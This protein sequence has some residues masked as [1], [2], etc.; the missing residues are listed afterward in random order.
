MTSYDLLVYSSESAI[1]MMFNDIHGLSVYPGDF[2]V[3]HRTPS[4]VDDTIGF[5]MTFGPPKDQMRPH[6]FT[7]HI[8]ASLTRYRLEDVFGELSLLDVY[9]PATVHDVL[10]HIMSTRGEIFDLDDFENRVLEGE[11][12]TITPLPDSLRWVGTLTVGLLDPVNILHVS[13]VAPVDNIDPLH[14]PVTGHLV[15]LLAP[16]TTIPDPLD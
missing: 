1:A 6:R 9:Y 16:T 7:G 4:T 12:V 11:V 2:T 3:S 13:D 15:S 14:L 8:T 10:T 5:R